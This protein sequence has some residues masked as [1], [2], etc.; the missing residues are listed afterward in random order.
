MNQMNPQDETMRL[1]RVH[2]PPP[3][4][5][6]SSVGD[7]EETCAESGEED[8]SCDEK[9][10]QQPIRQE[11]AQQGPSRHLLDSIPQIEHIDKPIRKEPTDK[12][13][14]DKNSTDKNSTD[15]NSS[16]DLLGNILQQI[17]QLPDDGTSSLQRLQP[18]QQH[19]SNIASQAAQRLKL[20]MY[21]MYSPS[22]PFQFKIGQTVQDI[23]QV[24]SRYKTF[25]TDV[26]VKM[27]PL[28]EELYCHCNSEK[29]A[30]KFLLQFETVVLQY[31]DHCMS[32]VKNGDLVYE[33][34]LFSVNFNI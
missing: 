31:L 22:V 24:L 3:S 34:L 30:K 10:S 20:S 4:Q 27:F 5:T 11:L 16:Q 13:S 1:N 9:P 25:C 6:Q 2:F 12:N 7:N 32:Y 15:K 23:S 19:F 28:N 8:E 14:T 21:L 29:E 26:K 18:S 17:S 33:S